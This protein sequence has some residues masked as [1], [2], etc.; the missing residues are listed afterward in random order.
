MKTSIH[1]VVRVVLLAVLGTVLAGS[2]CPPCDLANKR[3]DSARVVITTITAPPGGG[4]HRFLEIIASGFHPNAQGRLSIPHFP[5]QDG[6]T[7]ALLENI[8]FDGDGRL[9]WTKESIPFL[10]PQADGN[11]DIYVTVA[12]ANGGCFASISFKQQEFKKLF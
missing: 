2:K 8:T 5:T 1:I 4:A 6:N 3:I 9:Y 10:G 12:E 7:E 11:V